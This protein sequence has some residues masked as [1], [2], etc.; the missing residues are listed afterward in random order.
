MHE[1]SYVFG[2]QQISEFQPDLTFENVVSDCQ[3][4]T[5]TGGC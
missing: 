4:W 5:Q 3:A 1:G 2:G